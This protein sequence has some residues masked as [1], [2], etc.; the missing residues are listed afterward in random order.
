M[1]DM[2]TY[3]RNIDVLREFGF[4]YKS[5]PRGGKTINAFLWTPC[6]AYTEDADFPDEWVNILSRDGKDIYEKYPKDD[7]KARQKVLSE[8]SR[9]TVRIVYASPLTQGRTGRPRERKYRFIGLFKYYRH[10]TDGVHYR[11]LD[12]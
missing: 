11:K 3:S 2:K 10:D 8:R 4:D 1:D 12:V 7:T 9:N 6:V 5:F